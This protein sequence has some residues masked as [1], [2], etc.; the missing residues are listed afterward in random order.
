M[1]AREEDAFNGDFAF[2]LRADLCDG[3]VAGFDAGLAAVLFEGFTA[4][5]LSFSLNFSSSLPSL[6]LSSSS[7]LLSSGIASFGEESSSVV[8]S[9]ETDW[10]LLLKSHFAISFGTYPAHSLFADISTETNFCSLFE[11]KVWLSNQME[12]NS[13]PC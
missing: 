8:L 9:E 3:F 1:R 6:S 11:E 10:L 7:P 5:F 2:A 12:K 4:I 13:G